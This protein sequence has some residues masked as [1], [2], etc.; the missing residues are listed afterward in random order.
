MIKAKAY[1]VTDKNSK[2][3]IMDIERREVGEND[4]LIEIQYCGICH[5]DVHQVRN[6]WEAP[7]IPVVPGL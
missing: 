3:Q 7:Y 1:G 2:F 5:S 4:V 6:E